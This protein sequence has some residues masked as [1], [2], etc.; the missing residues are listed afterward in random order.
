[1]SIASLLTVNGYNIGSNSIALQKTTNQ[2]ITSANLSHSTTLNI[3]TMGQSTII[4]FPDPHSASASVAYNVGGALT[5]TT[6]DLTGTNGQITLSSASSDPLTINAPS[7]AQATVLNIPDPANA[8]SDFVLVDP[9]G[10][11]WPEINYTIS[12]NLTVDQLNY[13]TLNPPVSASNNYYIYSIAETETISGTLSSQFPIIFDTIKYQSAAND[14]TPL[15]IGSSP[16]FNVNTTGTYLIS[17]TITTTT[18]TNVMLSTGI[19]NS[20]LT[21]LFGQNSGSSGISDLCSSSG[22]ALLQC[23]TGD[24]IVLVVYINASN[25]GQDIG[26]LGSAGNSECYINFLK[27]A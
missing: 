13:T 5:G 15:A 26:Q 14:I 12:G 1:M 4:T 24:V 16:N 25:T 11:L 3:P 8:T 21:G 10:I 9:S 2:I 22:T 7:F 6:L 17:Y 23:N 27:I 20:N 19:Y 18:A